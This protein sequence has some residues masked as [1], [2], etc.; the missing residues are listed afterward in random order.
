VYKAHSVH[1]PLTFARPRSV[2]RSRPLFAR[3]LPNTGSTVA[4]RRPYASR[5]A[6]ARCPAIVRTLL[7][8]F[9]DW[10]MNSTALIGAIAQFVASPEGA[11]A[12]VGRLT[13]PNRSLPRVV[14]SQNE[15]ETLWPRLAEN[16]A[17]DLAGLAQVVLLD[18]KA[19]WALSDA[20][21]KR[22]SCYNGAV[23]LY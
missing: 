15:G 2:K 9:S 7:G 8:K 20:I 19:S 23:R 11:E 4:K 16:I 6:G 14:A 17:F 13:S 5:P 10:T 3:T 1:C 12:L 22:N 18:E 21:G